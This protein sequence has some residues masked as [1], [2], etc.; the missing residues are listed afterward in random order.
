MHKV[1]EYCPNE[2]INFYNRGI[3]YKKMDKKSE[4]IQ[5]FKRALELDPNYEYAKQELA[6]LESSQPR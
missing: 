2:M 4:A 3:A 6:E 5:D 1:I